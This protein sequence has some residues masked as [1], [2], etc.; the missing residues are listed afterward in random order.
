MQVVDIL[1]LAWCVCEKRQS[2]KSWWGG[3]TGQPGNCDGGDRRVPLSDVGWN[4]A[5]EVGRHHSTA[6]PLVTSSYKYSTRVQIWLGDL[7]TTNM[8]YFVARIESDQGVSSSLTRANGCHAT[9]VEAPSK[10]LC[11]RFMVFTPTRA[12]G[13]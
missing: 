7:A 5:R 6:G 9:C 8:L 4:R 3:C 11:V 12:R 13:G 2:V 1:K 10:I